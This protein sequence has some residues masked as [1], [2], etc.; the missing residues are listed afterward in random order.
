MGSGFSCD[1]LPAFLEEVFLLPERFVGSPLGC[2]HITDQ[3]PHPRGITNHTG[4]V[5]LPRR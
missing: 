1:L 5:S 3:H 2:A 4:E